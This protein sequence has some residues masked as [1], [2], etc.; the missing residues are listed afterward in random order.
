MTHW[1]MGE[2]FQLSKHWL[3]NSCLVSSNQAPVFNA[4]PL[5]EVTYLWALETPSRAKGPKSAHLSRLTS[6]DSQTRNQEE[7]TK[8]PV[9]HCSNIF[10]S[11]NTI[12]PY[13]KA[14]LL[15]FFLS[16]HSMTII[17]FCMPF[18]KLGYLLIE[19][20]TV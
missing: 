6:P 2:T 16:G 13:F 15:T 10:L 18:L 17:H 14:D 9:W 8:A 7:Q 1:C 5:T 19:Q 20:Y 11:V 12:F 4:K 3:W